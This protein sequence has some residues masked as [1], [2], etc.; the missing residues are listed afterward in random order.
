MSFY[1]V[2]YAGGEIY[3]EWRARIFIFNEIFS[4][5]RGAYFLVMSQLLL[6][7]YD[8]LMEILIYK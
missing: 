1:S 3:V 5:C 2:H 6:T 7:D 8:S 4:C